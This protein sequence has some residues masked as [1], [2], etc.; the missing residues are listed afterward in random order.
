[1]KE[2]KDAHNAMMVLV[3]KIEKNFWRKHYFCLLK[4][5]EKI[6]LEYTFNPSNAAVF[7]KKELIALSEKNNLSLN[8]EMDVILLEPCMIRIQINEVLLQFSVSAPK[9]GQKRFS[10]F[11]WRRVLAWIQG[12]LD[13]NTESLRESVKSSYEK[14]YLHPKLDVITMTSIKSL[15]VSY[16]KEKGG[17]FK[18]IRHPLQSEIYIRIN[19]DVFEI[20]VFHKSFNENPAVLAEVLSK[21]HAVEIENYLTCGK[22]CEG[23]EF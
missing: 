21:P 5:I 23:W 7:L 10:F 13:I 14:F 16:I 4:K 22:I 2:D 12:Y 1:M 20:H 8:E 18:L 9:L 17:T 11:E 15:C 19:D 6:E 3:E